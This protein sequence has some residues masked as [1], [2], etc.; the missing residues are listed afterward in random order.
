MKIKI[1]YDKILLGMLFTSKQ[2]GEKKEK[3]I[4]IMQ[5]EKK[6]RITWIY[7]QY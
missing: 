1:M 3:I 4:S 5:K 7:I 2:K 6:D